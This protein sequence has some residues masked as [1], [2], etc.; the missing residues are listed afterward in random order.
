MRLSF[1][2]GCALALGACGRGDHGGAEGGGPARPALAASEPAVASIG[3]APERRRPAPP[4]AVALDGTPGLHAAS[5]PAPGR[6]RVYARAQRVWVHERPS[7]RSPRLGYLRAGA[8]SPTGDAAGGRDGCRDG[9]Y[10]VEP[11]GWVCVGSG[12]ATLDPED[13]IVVATRESPPDP[14]RK[15]PYVY[16][17]V[18]RP[19]PVY[20]AVP[21]ASDLEAAEP[22][23]DER[24]KT[25]LAADGEVGA[26]FAQHVW[27]GGPGEPPD[28]ARTWEERRSDVLPAWLAAGSVVPG[29]GKSRE[30]ASLGR[31]KPKVGYSFLRTFLHE[32]RRY[33]LSAALEVVPT[34]RLRPIQGSDF[35]GF[36]IGAAVEFPFAIV[37][38][39]DARLWTRSKGKLLEAG[40]APYRAPL[41]LTGKQNFFDGRLHFETTDGRWVS[42]RDA[43]RLDAARRMPKWGTDGERWID[44][45]VTKQ[46]LVLYEGT[47][48]VYA[49]LVSTG[50]A[51]LEHHEGST[52]TKRG[53]FRIHTKHVST[54]MASDEIGEEF[55]LRDVP[56]V[57]YF[58]EGY[59]LHG[60]YWHDRFGVPKS[61]GC[62]NLAPEDARRI[63]YWTEPALPIGWHGVLLPL[64][65]TT[66][67]V[68]P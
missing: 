62:I 13:P 14:L 63:F 25:W 33:G 17:T 21:T 39:P 30:G 45:N 57:Q 22:D 10:S 49:T 26:G 43:S 46:T 44:V 58:D 66:I 41:P 3:P 24:M 55:E 52:A 15:L 6:P 56:Y 50:E 16:G 34:D 48:A 7:S 37:R 38:R 28:P 27:L 47:R 8:S 42:D 20:A 23:L 1:G 11:E 32:G 68:H 53:I 65:G 36:A 5:V 29:F 31:M 35:Q 18:R 51:G 2:L 59:A 54:T 61:H 60:A 67:F 9:W 4:P 64:R 40:V 12:G 19:G